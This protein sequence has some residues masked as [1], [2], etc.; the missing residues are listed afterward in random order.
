[1]ILHNLILNL[2]NGIFFNFT[3]K[4][5]I[6]VVKRPPPKAIRGDPGRIF[7]VKKYVPCIYC[8]GFFYQAD[9]SKHAR[10]ISEFAC[11]NAPEG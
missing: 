9:V 1:M 8:L 10:A 3:G 7:R 6:V 11:P 2:M 4:G 5:E